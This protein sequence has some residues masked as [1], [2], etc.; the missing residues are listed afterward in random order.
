[1]Y[2]DPLLVQLFFSDFIDRE[3]MI[4]VLM[5]AK[6]KH[7]ET[8]AALKAIDIPAV[9]KCSDYE[10]LAARLTLELGFKSKSAYIDW[11]DEAIEAIRSMDKK[12]KRIAKR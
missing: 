9:S 1:M 7:E 3:T 4:A 12:S 8:L 6:A 5:S 2:R 11:L 10:Q